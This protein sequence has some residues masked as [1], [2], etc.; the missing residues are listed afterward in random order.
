MLQRTSSEEHLAEAGGQRVATAAE[1]PPLA[2]LLARHAYLAC[3]A[4]RGS[5]MAYPTAPA[6]T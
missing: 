3:W 1:G 6:P 2:G 5:S 4:C